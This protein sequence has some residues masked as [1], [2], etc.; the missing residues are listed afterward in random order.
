M[1]GNALFQARSRPPS[2][3]NH[4]GAANEEEEPDPPRNFTLK[5]LRHFDGTYDESM[6]ENKSVYLALAGTVY[7]VTQG[8]EFYGPGGPYENFAARECG[9]A[10]AKMSFDEKHLDDV[11][12]CE[13]L[14]FG[15]KESLDGW[16]QQF[17]Y[18]KNYPIIG[19]VIP[20]EK[21]PSPSRIV[22]KEEL[23]KNK[24]KGEIPEGYAT[25]PIYIGADGKVF[26]VSFGGVLFY[27]EGCSYNRFAG[28][29]ASRAL[30]KMSFDPADVENPDC[31][32]LTEKE[33]KILRDWVK[34]FEERKG[35]PCVGLLPS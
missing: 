12:G 1:A 10:L 30:A 3:P 2:A 8:K 29:D 19:K 15:E 23:A 31:S 34:T 14:S 9:V 24:G 27:G 35:Y 5:Q 22:S 32:T 13:N 25:A 21:L 11:V 7:D 4:E 16:I 17:K 33:K 6:K 26:D 18:F 20:D 28:V